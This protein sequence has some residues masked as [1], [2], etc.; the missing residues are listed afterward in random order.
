MDD[1]LNKTSCDRCEASLMDGLGRIMSWFINETIC[2]TCSAKEAQLKKKL[3]S[4]DINPD[5]YE[6]CGYIP[7]WKGEKP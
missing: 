5:D 6:G 7:N 2:L 4:I 3:I 1:F